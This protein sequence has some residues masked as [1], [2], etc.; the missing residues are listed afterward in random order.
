M[1]SRCSQ[2]MEILSG[3]HSMTIFLLQATG[4]ACAPLLIRFLKG[5]PA[6]LL[7]ISFC[8]HGVHSRWAADAISLALGMDFYAA[9]NEGA[10]IMLYRNE[11]CMPLNCIVIDCCVLS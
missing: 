9:D 6:R 8:N 11:R 2:P 7:L 5:A 3:L 10:H 1:V 4:C